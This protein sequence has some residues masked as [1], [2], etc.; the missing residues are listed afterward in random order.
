[1]ASVDHN[2]LINE[3]Q[4]LHWHQWRGGNFDKPDTACELGGLQY[5]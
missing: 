4:S 3:I 2:V 5:D 1:M